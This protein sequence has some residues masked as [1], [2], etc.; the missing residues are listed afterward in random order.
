MNRADTER[1]RQTHI[2][3]QTDT[4]ER[5]TMAAFTSDNKNK[6]V[7]QFTTVTF[8]LIIIIRFICLK[9]QHHK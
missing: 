8:L 1:E 6:T 7:K 9:T 4:T 3:T 5:I 2:H